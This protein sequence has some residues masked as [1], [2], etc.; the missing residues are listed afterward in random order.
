MAEPSLA[1]APELLPLR[2]RRV[3]PRV[4]MLV[5]APAD[6]ELRDE[7]RR[8]ERP[9]PEYL[10]LEADFGVELLD[11]SQVRGAQR[12][13]AMHSARHVRAAM[14]RLEGLDVVFSDGEH[15]G[16]PM[17][18]A[19]RSVRGRPAHLMIGHHLTARAKRTLF[20]CLG[21]AAAIDRVL[22]HSRHQLMGAM[23]TLAIARVSIVLQPYHVDTDFWRPL[24]VPE[25]ALLVAPGLEHRDHKTLA[26]AVA[27]LPLRVFVT[28]SSAHS[29]T[30][31]SS[32]PEA[33][34]ANFQHG[35][36]SYPGLREIYAR[37]QI[38]VVPL[39]PADF[40][41]GV[42]TIL[43]AM[44]CGKALVV[45]ATEGRPDV[46]RDGENCRLVRPGSSDEL[47][48]AVQGLLA[49]PGERRRLG[50]NALV[51]ARRHGLDVYAEGIAEHLYEMGRR[52][53]LSH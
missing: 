18:L 7:V 42:T 47:R 41:A 3:M 36:P 19:L 37:S 16:L 25:E 15:V 2:G 24:D 44:A 32:I 52:D 43:E 21:P 20:G 50:G 5:S 22:V 51:D 13:S 17:A 9:C 26:A 1:A 30:A 53:H 6:E 46:L 12:R 10:R 4:L 33:W 40:P 28:A 45:S 29:A 38:V 8:G 31:R 23:K 14:R 39:L 34:P 35:R 49:N 48:A 11:W 27:D